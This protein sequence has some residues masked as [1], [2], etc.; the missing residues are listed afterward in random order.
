MDFKSTCIFIAFIAIACGIVMGW[1]EFQDEK[2]GRKAPAGIAGRK[3]PEN[4][5][6]EPVI[7]SRETEIRE[8]EPVEAPRQ[9]PVTPPVKVPDP[10]DLS[11]SSADEAELEKISG[12]IDAHKLPDASRAARQLVENK[13]GMLREKARQLEARIRIL[14]KL[15][16]REVGKAP[17]LKKVV[18]ANKSEHICTSV[19]ELSL[20]HI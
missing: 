20:I 9:E 18:H 3:P 2:S 16:P 13:G 6:R 1:K 8:P 19:Q 11:I 17:A 15:E 14:Q 4:G 12:L 7:P 5:D 10:I